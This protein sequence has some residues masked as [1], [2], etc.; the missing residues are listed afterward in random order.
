METY[1]MIARHLG[2]ISGEKIYAYNKLAYMLSLGWRVMYFS[3]NREQLPDK[4]SGCIHRVYPAVSYAPD[5]YSKGEVR[6]TVER[7]AA[8]IGDA[9]DAECIIESDA[10]NRSAWAELVAARVGARHV[11][12]LLQEKHSYD[13]ETK[14]FLRF[15]Y[16]RHELA[17]I[18][19][20]SV[21]MILGDDSVER[22]DDTVIT[23]Y[24]NN[25]VEDCEDTVTARLSPEADLV[26]G[27]LGRLDKGCVPA[28][29]QGFKAYAASHPEQRIEL[30][31]IGGAMRKKRIRWIRREMRECGNIRLTVTGFM[32]PIPRTLIE[33]IDLFVS[34]AGSTDVTY[35][36]HRPTIKVHP[37]TGEPVGVFGLDDITEKTLFDVKPEMTIESCIERALAN[38][39][40]IEYRFDY[41][42]VYYQLM[43]A[44]FAR[45][46]TIAERAPQAEYYDEEK[47]MNLR[48]TRIKAHFLHRLIG[49]LF[50]ANALE[51]AVNLLKRLGG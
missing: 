1:V 12:F 39:D 40:R 51:G 19:P 13:P 29:L 42:N 49:H 14:R 35:R 43:D 38:A 16:D 22:R 32:Y 25:V 28:I 17:G 21:N 27:S 15:K 7:I 10:V 20:A 8:E 26:F 30:V 33:K 36:F 34:T 9:G 50:G 18:N 2:T 4:L 31:L 23:A 6:R 5:C 3:G 41:Y 44:E 48:T 37:L 24:C 11:A 46:L 45:Q 47:L